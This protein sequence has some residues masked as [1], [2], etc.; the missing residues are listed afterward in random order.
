MSSRYSIG[1]D[2][3]TNSVRSLVVNIATGEE[4]GA[5]VYDYPHGEAGILLDPK[6]PHLARQHPV[7]HVKGA[8]VA[9]SKAV[10]A[11]A[12]KD[13]DFSPEAVVGIGV[14]TTGSTPLPVDRNGKP[15]A[16]DPAFA[17]NLDAMAYLW[18]DHTGTAEAAEITALAAKMRPAYLRKCGGVYSSEWFFS[19]ILHCLRR[20]PRVFDAAYI[21]V[22]CSDWVPAILTGTDAPATIQRDICAA[23]HKAM[24]NTDWGGYPDKEFLAALDPKMGALRSKLSDTC[25]A[26][27]Q[28]VGGLTKEWAAKT[29]LRAGTPVAAGA[30]DAHL[31][32]VGSGIMPGQMV[33]ILGTSACQM[34]IAAAGI[35]L[36]DI[37]GVCGVVNG[38]IVPGHFGIETGQSAVGDVYNWFVNYLQPGGPENGSHRALTERASRLKPGESGLLALEWNNGNRCVLVDYRLGGLLLGQTLQTRPEEIYRALIEATAFGFLVIINRVEE[39]GVKVDSVINCGGIADKNPL[40]LQIYADVTGRP[41]RLSRSA[42]TCALG[43]AVAGAAAGGGHPSFAAAQKAMTGLKET[44]YKPNARNHAVYRDLFAL[45]KDLHDAFGTREWKGNLA[46]VMKRLIEIRERVE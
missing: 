24:F 1:L 11:A 10:A 8:E 4:V 29:G 5:C 28:A 22:E 30:F 37:P 41:M 38:A 15:L 6:D 39:Y 46:H 34:V 42:Q 33:Q 35:S 20:A 32:A 40:V 13:R 45:Y 31:G 36:P 43:A 23:G 25:V 17:D 18:K 44:E 2:Y 27:D 16:F 21:W 26:A 7:D 9:L 12:G 3:G 19:K 14:D